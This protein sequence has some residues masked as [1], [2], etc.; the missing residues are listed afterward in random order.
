MAF[1]KASYNREYYQKHKD[2]W[3]RYYNVGQ[4]AGARNARGGNNWFENTG[5]GHKKDF[6]K[7]VTTPASTKK[8]AKNTLS[9]KLAYASAKAGKTLS[10]YGLNLAKTG[11]K[12]TAKAGT[13]VGKAAK[14]LYNEAGKVYGKHIGKGLTPAQL[15]KKKAKDAYKAAGIEWSN[16][17]GHG[18]TPIQLVKSKIKKEWELRAGKGTT[19]KQQ[20]KKQLKKAYKKAQRAWSSKHD[21][22][23]QRYVINQTKAGVKKGAKTALKYSGKAVAETARTGMKGLNAARKRAEKTVSRVMSKYFGS[24][25][26]KAASKK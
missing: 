8:K 2:Y 25:K 10:K 20:V 4:T 6:Y 16:R 15:I 7:T 19:P 18:K 5:Y 22:T 23:P 17:Y 11:R 12:Y 21:V 14:G 26:K 24:G 9:K 13:V 3:Q 1:D